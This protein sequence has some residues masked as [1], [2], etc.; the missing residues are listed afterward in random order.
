MP[1]DNA[2]LYKAARAAAR[3]R[4]GP[5]LSLRTGRRAHGNVWSVPHC[6]ERLPLTAPRTSMRARTLVVVG[7]PAQPLRDTSEHV[8][9]YRS[10]AT[11]DLSP[12]D[13]RF[14]NDDTGV[15]AYPRAMLLPVV[16]RAC[17]HGIVSS[18]R[19]DRLCREHTTFIA[20]CG[21]TA[22]HFTTIAHI[23]STFR[24]DIARVFAAV[25]AIWFR[26]ALTGREMFAIAGVK[27]PSNAS[28][29][30]SGTRANFERQTTTCEAAAAALLAG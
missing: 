30:R 21:D 28:K 23:G 13:A 19:I 27:L 11:G 26:Q 17:A 15:P 14:C 25:R 5:M 29:R 9:H 8:A 7:L 12:F 3:T 18:R 1:L 10:H 6:V 20:L 24:A 2:G 22:P 4:V 16:L